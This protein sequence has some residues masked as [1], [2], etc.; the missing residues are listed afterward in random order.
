MTP[1]LF[2][3]WAGATT[4]GPELRNQLG[5]ILILKKLRKMKPILSIVTPCYN[6]EENIRNIRK[7][8]VEIT[9]A[10]KEYKFEHIFI[11]NAST[12]RTQRILRDMS[13][14]DKNLKVIFNLKNFGQLRSPYH[15]LLQANGAAVILIAADFQ[16]PPELI[17]KFIEE[18]QNGHDVVIG[19]KNKSKEHK[20]MFALRK[21]YYRLIKRMSE[22]DQIEN[23]TGFG[24]YSRSFLNI[25]RELPDALPYFRG[26]VAE[27]S[28]N[29]SEICYTQPKRE[30]G[31]T[32]NNFF[33]LYDVAMVGFVNHSKLPLRISSFIGFGMAL[34][35][36]MIALFYLV[37]KIT[38]WN[39]FD[40]GLAPLIIGLFFFS[41]VQL[42][43]IG[44][45]GE[46]IGAIYTQSKKRPLVIERERLNFDE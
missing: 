35:S 36:L 30:N 45:I 13:K 37:F 16:D 22:T 31:K 40:L 20:L 12:D 46:Y 7:K 41:S 1:Q 23:F 11:D 27:Y 14:Q 4:I 15:G 39:E 8:V 34:L 26:L 9:S 28:V 6:E 17:K 44:I 21:A 29:R 33:T 32:K 10:I 3:L 43:F 42:F 25:L 19:I 24:L 18:W 2:R 38:H 5:P